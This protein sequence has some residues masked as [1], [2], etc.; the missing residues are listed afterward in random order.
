MRLEEAGRPTYHSHELA[1][2]LQ[3][4]PGLLLALGGLNRIL[5]CCSPYLYSP[6]LY[7]TGEK[8]VGKVMVSALREDDGV[9]AGTDHLWHS[10]DANKVK[11]L[12]LQHVRIS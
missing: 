8:G 9:L 1:A 12:I 6:M 11:F 7:D 10:A 2:E 4:F 5:L 3:V